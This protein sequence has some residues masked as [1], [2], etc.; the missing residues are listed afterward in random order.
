M[1]KIL[2]LSALFSRCK[3][4]SGSSCRLLVCESLGYRS[5]LCITALDADGPKHSISPYSSKLDMILRVNAKQ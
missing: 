2:N 5:D 4:G 1:F 3:A